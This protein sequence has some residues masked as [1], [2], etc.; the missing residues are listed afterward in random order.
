MAATP[1]A[2]TVRAEVA[3]RS[4]PLRLATEIDPQ[5]GVESLPMAEAGVEKFEADQWLGLFAPKGTPASVIEKWVAEINRVHL[6][7]PLRRVL[8][9][10]V[11]V[12]LFYH[13]VCLAG[14]S[15]LTGPQKFKRVW[16]QLRAARSGRA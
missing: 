14:N 12:S 1:A 4:L 2:Q 15:V 6:H 3:D 7:I 11:C 9:Q 10:P 8:V 5:E 16:T 13:D